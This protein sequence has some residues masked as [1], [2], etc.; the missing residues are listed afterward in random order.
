MS[1]STKRRY[2][3]SEGGLE[4][5]EP[6]SAQIR[7]VKKFLSEKVLE[8]DAQNIFSVDPGKREWWKRT[9]CYEVYVRSFMDS[10]EDGIGDLPGKDEK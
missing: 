6:G 4:D 5:R 9:V 10:N 2:E 8:L 7:T 3:E 1:D